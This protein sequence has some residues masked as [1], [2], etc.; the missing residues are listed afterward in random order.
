MQRAGGN[1]L[2][3]EEL[4]SVVRQTGSVADLP[5]SLDALVS[6]QIDALAPLPKRLLR[7]ASVLGRSFRLTVL[8]EI[9]RDDPLELD[10]NAQDSL[11]GFLSADGPDRMRFRHGLLRD[12]AYEGLSYRR[13]REL[14]SKAAHATERLAGDDTDSVADLLALHYSLAQ[15]YEPTWRYA[16]MAGDDARDAYANVDAAV[17]YERAL[18][19]ARR[20]PEVSNPRE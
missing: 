19:A 11:A 9:L 5:D 7:Y 12:V 15:E 20:L 8:N 3:L 6:A 4:L 13:R 10:S 17:Q 2:F 14:H 18:A 16:R 1:P